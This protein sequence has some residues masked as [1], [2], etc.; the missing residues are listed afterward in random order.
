MPILTVES[1]NGLATSEIFLMLSTETLLKYYNR[2]P[3]SP[4]ISWPISSFLA[5]VYN[6]YAGCALQAV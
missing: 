6:K 3:L 4:L 1:R 5:I 2:V